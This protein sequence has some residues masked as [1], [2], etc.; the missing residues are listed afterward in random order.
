MNITGYTISKNPEH[1]H[2]PNIPWYNLA[3]D[4]EIPEIDKYKNAYKYQDWYSSLKYISY[5]ADKRNRA[6]EKALSLHP[7]TD[8]IL[9]CDSYFLEQTEALERLINDYRQLSIECNL[10]GA[11]W[12]VTRARISHLIRQRVEWFDKWGVPELR[13]M[14]PDFWPEK[15]W[16]AFRHRPP[17]SGLYRVHSLPGVYI[18][19][20]STWEKGARC[21]I[22]E[23]MH[24]C[25]HETLCEASGIPTYIDLNAKFWRRK[26][27]PV[28]KC[29]RV[30]LNL[31]RLFQNF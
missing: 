27:Y 28:M 26:V 3:E 29:I 8:A 10:G 16:V 30:S 25:E 12:G 6:I 22:T 11:V 9:C 4:T 5:L 14:P 20:R 7:E 23:D 17:L 19:P 18:F 13:W 24:S 1:W 2:L 21:G 31:G 15:D